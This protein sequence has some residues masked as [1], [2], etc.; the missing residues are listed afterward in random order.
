MRTQLLLLKCHCGVNGFFCL[1]RNNDEYEL[2]PQ[3]FFS[4]PEIDTHLAGAISGWNTVTITHHLEQLGLSISKY[5]STL[6]LLLCAD[7]FPRLS[8]A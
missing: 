7:V 4:D 5:N 8:G 2:D 1:T 3:W 6:S